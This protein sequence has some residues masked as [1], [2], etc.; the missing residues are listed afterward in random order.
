MLPER[1]LRERLR[2]VDRA[3]FFIAT[4]SKSLAGDGA[5]QRMKLLRAAEHRIGQGLGRAAAGGRR[6]IRHLEMGDRILSV[7]S[8]PAAKFRRRRRAEI[9]ARISPS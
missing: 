4:S 9:H 8:V 2:P 7:S 5:L 3:R 1:R 6:R